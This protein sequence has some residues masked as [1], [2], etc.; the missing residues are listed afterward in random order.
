MR[1]EIADYK[2]SLRRRVALLAGVAESALQ[3]V[4][5][6]RLQLNPGV[7]TFVQACRHAGLKT[8][9]VSG[10]FTFFSDRVRERLQLDF[11]RAN[12]LGTS[13][14]RL[15]GTLFDQPWGDICDGAEK[16]RVLLEVVRADGHLDRAGHRGGRRRQ[17][18]AD[19]ERGRSVDR[20]PRQARGARARRDLDRAR[21]HGAR[22]R[23]AESSAVVPRLQWRG[24][25][26]SS[27]V[28]V[29]SSSSTSIGL[30][31]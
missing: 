20:L 26:A 19:D 11:A 29:R 15:T 13:Q 28:T 18:P 17:R 16:R 12:M 2:E 3:R 8:L 25:A 10:G 1:G 7:E 24:G 6:E 22:A 9:L 4:Y 27:C 31:M 23:G 5:D 30:V 14:G 21:R